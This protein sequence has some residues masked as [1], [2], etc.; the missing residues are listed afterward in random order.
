MG[1]ADALVEGLVLDTGRG[2]ETAAATEAGSGAAKAGIAEAL[3]GLGLLLSIR[4]DGLNLNALFELLK[5]GGEGLVDGA[6]LA[7]RGA[8]LGA[9]EVGCTG[10][11]RRWSVS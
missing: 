6:G 9:L 11:S 7:Q 8:G 10:L 2:L 5:V 3:V 1:G 4:V